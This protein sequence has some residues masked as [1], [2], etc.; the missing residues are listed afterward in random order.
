MIFLSKSNLT[1]G[2]LFIYLLPVKRQYKLLLL[3]K[4]TDNFFLSVFF[5][6]SNNAVLIQTYTNYNNKL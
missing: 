5:I 2:L 6:N 4:K 1:I 3:I